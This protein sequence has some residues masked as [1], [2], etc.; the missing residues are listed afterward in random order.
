MLLLRSGWNW[1][2]YTVQ[3]CPPRKVQYGH[4]LTSWYYRPQTSTF[5]TTAANF[6]R[7]CHKNG[8]IFYVCHDLKKV[9]KQ[10]FSEELGYPLQ[11]VNENDSNSVYWYK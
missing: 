3:W 8:V 4:K 1:N 2:L 9:G 11:K 10:Y 5:P 6:P 7:V